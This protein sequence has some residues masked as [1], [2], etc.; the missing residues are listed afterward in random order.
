MDKQAILE[1][2][3]IGFGVAIMLGAVWFW[4]LQVQDTLEILRMAAG[5]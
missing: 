4:T 5:Q 1:K 2:V 3:S